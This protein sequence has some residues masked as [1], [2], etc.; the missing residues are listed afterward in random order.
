MILV[1]RG[2]ASGH[3]D[4]S[5]NE[6]IGQGFELVV[7]VLPPRQADDPAN[8]HAALVSKVPTPQ[9]TPLLSLHTH[10]RHHMDFAPM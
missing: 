2:A 7:M 8:A 6:Q 10:S 4:F 5:P 9:I 3:E 1:R